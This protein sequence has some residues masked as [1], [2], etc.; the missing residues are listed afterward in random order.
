MGRATQEKPYTMPTAA[1]VTAAQQREGFAAF[2]VAGSRLPPAERRRKLDRAEVQQYRFVEGGPDLAAGKHVVLFVHGYNVT[3][4]DAL[5]SFA[6]FFHRLHTA[7]AGDQVDMAQV[8]LLGFTW[9]GDVGSL[10]FDGAQDMAHGSGVALYELAKDLAAAG[11]RR[12][13]LVTHSL[14]AH[15]GLR[16]LSVL[17]QRRFSKPPAERPA[18]F[19]SVLL[20]APAVEND[21]FERP[22][23]A[24]RYH[25]PESAFGMRSLNIFASRADTVLRTAFAT[26]E[27]DK[28]LGYAG[29]ES[30]G[31][32]ASLS[33]RVKE[34]LDDVF[35]FELHD[36]SPQSAT[37][38]NPALHAHGHSDY[39]ERQPQLDYYANYV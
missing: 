27:F 25:F 29:P 2:A 6:G 20:L 32:L 34:V 39:W 36:F 16:A 31:P 17:G 7:L 1:R 35:A 21:V 38:I 28:A 3:S 18:P 4:E 24:E 9:P 12:L 14:G 30:M 15:V 8:L 11:A 22:N 5:R 19:D 10:H 33:R 23:L 13:T 37:I 26:S